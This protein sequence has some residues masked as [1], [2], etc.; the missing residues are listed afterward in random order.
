MTFTAPHDGYYQV[1]VTSKYNNLDKKWLNIS[2]YLQR[3][4]IKFQGV[5]F[6]KKDEITGPFIGEK[7]KV[8]KLFTI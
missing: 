5:I 6:L 4:Y 8:I 1:T 2:K 3:D 7:L